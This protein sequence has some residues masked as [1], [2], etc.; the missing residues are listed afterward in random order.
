MFLSDLGLDPIL[1]RHRAFR[2]RQTIDR[3][4][5]VI[6]TPAVRRAPLPKASSDA[7]QLSDLDFVIRCQQVRLQNTCYAGNTL[8][9]VYAEGTLFFPA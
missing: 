8:P 9:N 3:V 6:T 7:E 1:K 5:I 4:C 2:Y